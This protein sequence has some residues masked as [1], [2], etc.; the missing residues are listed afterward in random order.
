[1]RSAEHVA[2]MGDMRNK[3]KILTGKPEGKRPLGKPSRRW[4]DNIR[5]DLWGKS[6]RSCGLVS[7]GS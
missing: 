1:M 5:M 3:Y 6:V 4:E 7:S 2:R